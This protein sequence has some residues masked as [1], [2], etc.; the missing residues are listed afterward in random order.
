MEV[1]S[2]PTSRGESSGAAGC[3]PERSGARRLRADVGLVLVHGIGEQREGETLTEAADAIARWL[4]LGHPE[5]GARGETAVIL[6]PPQPDRSRGTSTEPR[7]LLLRL[8]VKRA[9]HST[10]PAEDQY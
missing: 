5:Q 9:L 8:N 2:S 6:E 1:S 4:E 7:H 10:G 3:D